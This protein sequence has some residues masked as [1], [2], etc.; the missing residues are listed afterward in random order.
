MPFVARNFEIKGGA[1]VLEILPGVRRR[2]PSVGLMV[3]GPDRPDP[4]LPVVTGSGAVAAPICT[5]G[6][7]QRQTFLS[8]RLRS[9]VLPSWSWRQ[10]RTDSRLSIPAPSVCRH[11]AR[12]RGWIAER[13]RRCSCGHTGGVGAADRQRPKGEAKHGRHVS[14]RYSLVHMSPQ[15]HP[16]RRPPP[17]RRPMWW[18]LPSERSPNPSVRTAISASAWPGIILP[19]CTAS[20]GPQSPRGPDGSTALR[21]GNSGGASASF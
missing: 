8:I 16:R 21:I 9:T 19:S 5:S 3:A 14:E 17:D 4:H 11:R 1:A 18:C 10:W 7:I 20:F 6:S 12:R 2:F 13:A 15:Q